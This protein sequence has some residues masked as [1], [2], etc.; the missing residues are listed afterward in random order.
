MKAEDMEGTHVYF[1]FCLHGVLYDVSMYFPVALAHYIRD[2]FTLPENRYMCTKILTSAI[3]MGCFLKLR[4]TECNTCS[5][6]LYIIKFYLSA[7]QGYNQAHFINAVRVPLSDYFPTK[8]LSVFSDSSK[9]VLYRS[10]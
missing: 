1:I 9:C 3:R 4:T 6:V 7:K 8:T 2:F 5:Y 10:T